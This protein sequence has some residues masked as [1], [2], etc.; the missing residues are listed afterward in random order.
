MP[1]KP[2]HS[3]WHFCFILIKFLLKRIIS[4]R[5]MVFGERRALWWVLDV[6]MT[7]LFVSILNMSIAGVIL[8]GIVMLLRRALGRMLPAVYQ[9]LLWLPFLFRLLVPYSLPSVFSV[10]NLFHQKMA[11]PGGALLSVVYLDADL[12]PQ[13]LAPDTS[14]TMTGVLLRAGCSLWLAGVAVLVLLFAVQ[15]LRLAAAL[16]TARPL[17]PTALVPCFTQAG[18]HRPVA[19][20][21]TRAVSGPMVFGLLRPKVLLPVILEGQ[22]AQRRYILLHELVH[23]RRRDY[24]ILQVS[25]LALALHW[26]NPVVWLARDRMAQDIERACDETVLAI[27]GSAEQLDYAQ[28]LVDWAGRHRFGLAAYAAFGERD[29]TTR[30]RRILAWK[31]LPRWAGALLSAAVVA[32]FLCTAT[33]P[34]IADNTY[35]PVSSPFVSEAQKERFRQTAYR[36]QQALEAGDVPL[37]TE[38]A[39]MDGDYFE[40]LYTGLSDLEMQVEDM[41]LFFNSEQSAELYLNVAVADGAGLYEPGQGTLVAHMSQTGYREQ[42]L[43]D[44]LMTRQKYEGIRLADTDSEAARLA[45]RLCANLEQPDFVADSLSPVTVARVCMASAI[46]DKGESGPFSPKRMEELAR[47]YFSL[48]GFSC[49]DP[50][51]YDAASGTYFYTEAPAPAMRVTELEDTGGGEMRVVVECYDDPLCL[52]PLRRMECRLQR[53]G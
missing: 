17:P 31:R 21:Y 41:R 16:R 45:L 9:Y 22:A 3:K 30:V 40:P 19:V 10:F 47:E 18:L 36:L 4:D 24:L 6:T 28:A 8:F 13:P 32:V 42:P 34:V 49:R 26:F 35:L 46:E 11:R 7:E 50:A 38:Q 33:N 5:S 23:V 29:V 12:V 37:L 14:S 52:Y 20:V 43:V 48:E 53:A 25:N 1:Q 2:I 51:V 39:S 44:C 27:V 15:Y